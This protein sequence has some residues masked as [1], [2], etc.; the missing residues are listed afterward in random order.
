MLYYL[1]KY[2]VDILKFQ[3]NIK[4]NILFFEKKVFKNIEMQG[5]VEGL[6]SRIVIL[7]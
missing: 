6:L 1:I 4:Y 5:I 2:R 7:K 3:Y